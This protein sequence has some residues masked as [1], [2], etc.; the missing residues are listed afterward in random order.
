MIAREARDTHHRAAVLALALVLGLVAGIP[1]SRTLGAEVARIILPSQGGSGVSLTAIERANDAAPLAVRSHDGFT[2]SLLADEVAGDARVFQYAVAF[3]SAGPFTD[4]LG[5]PRVVNPDGSIVLPSEYGP[6]QSIDEGLALRPGLASGQ[7]SAAVFDASSIQPGGVLRF[8][9]FFRSDEDGFALQAT[10]GDLLA[11]VSLTLL[12]EPFEVTMSPVAEGLYEITFH[13]TAPA[14]SAVA[15]H[16]GARVTLLADGAPLKE[17][18]GSTNF[19]KTEDLEVNAN[20]SA[21]VV[22]GP[23]LE[24]GTL[25]EVAADSS[26]TV[27]AGQWDFAID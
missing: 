17:V 10:Y 21:V 4:M 27:I 20:S 18:R 24:P 23:V 14:P 25:I 3:E 5:I 9:P 13:A 1:L 16:P 6:V 22:A 15:T 11:G 26:G 7:G 19:A 12:G 2:V 8:G